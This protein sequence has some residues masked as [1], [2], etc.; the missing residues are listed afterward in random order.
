MRGEQEVDLVVHIHDFVLGK[1]GEDHQRTRP[2][3][4]LSVWYV[5]ARHPVLIHE[6]PERLV[7][8]K[9]TTFDRTKHRFEGLQKTFL[10]VARNDKIVSRELDLS[11]EWRGLSID[12]IEDCW[13]SFCLFVFE[14][15]ESERECKAIGT[16]CMTSKQLIVRFWTPTECP[17]DAN[18]IRWVAWIGSSL[19]PKIMISLSL[20][21]NIKSLFWASSR[22]VSLHDFGT[23]WPWRI[24]RMNRRSV[25]NR[26]LVGNSCRCS[27]AISSV[28]G[29]LLLFEMTRCFNLLWFSMCLIKT[30]WGGWLC[31]GFGV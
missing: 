16:N 3:T 1:E 19:L 4:E 7:E 27:N 6:P 23:T 31:V 9:M 28:W 25:L 20:D 14:Q 15:R 26:R 2:W 8:M 17:V 5:A 12:F 22:M 29:R 11:A 24:L 30:S 18:T 21:W 10:E 13:V